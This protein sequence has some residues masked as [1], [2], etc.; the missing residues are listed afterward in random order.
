M[1]L[2][3]ADKLIALSEFYE[4]FIDRKSVETARTIEAIPVEWIDKHIEELSAQGHFLEASYFAEIM[5][6][7]R[8]KNE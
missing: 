6:L 3:D 4:T 7:W 2:I 5:S 8:D 1:R